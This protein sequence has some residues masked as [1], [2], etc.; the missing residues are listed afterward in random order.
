[1]QRPQQ[2]HHPHNKRRESE[3]SPTRNTP[4]APS[5]V[6]SPHA[7]H[8]DAMPAA[9]ATKDAKGNHSSAMGVCRPMTTTGGCA[10]RGEEEREA[11]CKGGLLARPCKLEPRSRQ[12]GTYQATSYLRPHAARGGLKEGPLKAE[13]QQRRD[14]S[15]RPSHQPKDRQRTRRGTEPRGVA[16]ELRLCTGPWLSKPSATAMV[17]E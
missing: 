3:A 17:P 11:E 10:R 6:P 15:C 1:M 7:V 8:S 4:T 2:G 16:W 12:E 14:E 5:C 9:A 13:Q